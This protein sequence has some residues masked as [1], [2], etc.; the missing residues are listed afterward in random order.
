MSNSDNHRGGLP[1]KDDD[2]VM[3]KWLLSVK[4]NMNELIVGPFI[5]GFVQGFVNVVLQRR[6]EQRQ[7]KALL[8]AN[9]KQLLTN[10]G[11][12]TNNNDNDR[13]EG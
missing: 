5:T 12:T 11:N 8:S 3:D 6:R 1:Q 9:S 2:T 4:N 7:A 13:P 10:N